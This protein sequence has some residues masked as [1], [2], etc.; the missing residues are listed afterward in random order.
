MKLS[1]E[2]KNRLTNRLNKTLFIAIISVLMVSGQVSTAQGT[3]EKLQLLDVKT[4]GPVAGAHFTYGN[5][6]GITSESGIF[7]IRYD[8][9][10]SLYISHLA[11]G[12]LNIGPEKVE[13]MIIG[14]KIL[15]KQGEPEILQPVTVFA[16]RKDPSEG[17]NLSLSD[18]DRLSHDAGSYLTQTLAVAAIQ[19]SGNYGFD[20]V[21]R[22]FKYEQ[23]NLVIDGAQVA[24][25]ACPN[26]MDPP[27]SQVSLNQM[28]R[29]EILKG[30]YFLRYGSA[31]GGTI[32]FITPVP[33][34]S[35]KMEP[36]GRLST[37]YESNGNIFR[38]EGVLGLNH[39]DLMLNMAGSW[40]Q[41]GD[42]MDGDGMVIPSEFSRGSVGAS[43][44]YRLPGKQY[45]SM[46]LSR[47]FARDVIFAALP[48]DLRRDDT[49]LV[50]AKHHIN[51]ERQKLKQWS[52]TIYFTHVSHLMDNLDKEMEPRM[53]N[54]ATDATTKSYGGRTEARLDFPFAGLYLGTDLRIEEAEGIRTREMLMGPM[55]GNIAEDNVWQ[56]GRIS[57]T[58]LFAEYQLNFFPVEM[59]LSGRLEVNKADV[60]NEASEFTDVYD[61]AQS[62]QLNPGLSLGI[63]K[64][65]NKSLNV[66][67]WLGRIKR[68]GS[69]TERFINYFPVGLDP[70]ELLGNP[71]IS[72]E[73]NNQADINLVFEKE[74]S[75][76]QMNVFSAYLQDYI[77]SAI[78]ADLEPRLPSSPGVR[79]YI[80]LDRA[81][82]T[83]FEI[84]WK[85]HLPGHLDLLAGIAYTYGKD[86]VNEEPLPEIA[87]LDMR[88]VLTGHFVHNSLRPE[89]LFRHVVRQDRVSESFGEN[90]TPGF[91]IFD[92]KLTY[93]IKQIFHVAGG[94]RNL[95]DVA[96]YE[97]LS[98]SVREA[99]QRPVYAPGRNLFLTVSMDLGN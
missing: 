34:F 53:V 62:L 68:S 5:Q 31:L 11:Y 6:R 47:N 33:R 4:S 54:T 71:A 38:T 1:K 39:P 89:I 40:S 67:I 45:V 97:H 70:Y 43:I 32:N 86:P 27:A 21:M 42:Y 60:L 98:R 15:I 13:E 26:R 29:V 69:L 20:P 93:D 24:I 85:Q 92:L 99:S 19:K 17:V 84:S 91:S 25:A 63:K 52:T 44:A 83:G 74:R 49:W 72:P 46:N 77:S 94:V 76:I 16:M 9:A 58:G 75:S 81:W 36:L 18:Y 35:E 66:G 73:I 23:L 2:H 61:D 96:Y 90:T 14:G 22:G 3:E 10:L 48:M 59:V 7:T 78:R 8:P 30:P 28:D 56:K 12:N 51:I 55:A 50:N 57:R 87:P 95:F 88:M 82:M 64:Q 65:L 79:Q 41:G 37:S 80:N